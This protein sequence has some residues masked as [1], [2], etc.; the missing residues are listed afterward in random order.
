MQFEMSHP[1]LKLIIYGV[2]QGLVLLPHLSVVMLS[3]KMREIEVPNE[4]EREIRSK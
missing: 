4:G 3:C 1:E 2:L